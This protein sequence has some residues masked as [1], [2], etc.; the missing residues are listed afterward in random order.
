M[1]NSFED[2]RVN[3]LVPD[4]L[5]E[6]AQNLI[7]FL[8][9][10]YENDANPA[11]IIDF[12]QQNRD[13]DRIANENF[14]QTL[15]ETVAKGLPDSSVVQKTFLLKR[16]VDYYNLK[17][18]NESIIIFFQLFYDKMIQVFE[19]W[20]RVLEPSSNEI[21]DTKFIR[22]VAEEGLNPY[23]L[24]GKTITQKNSFGLIE[25]SG[26]VSR[27]TVE[28]YDVLLY[29]LYLDDTG[30]LFSENGKIYEGN[31]LYGTT[32]LSLNNITVNDG[33]DGFNVGDLLF[34]HDTGQ[35]YRVLGGNVVFNDITP[36]TTFLARIASVDTDGRVLQ[37]KLIQRGSGNSNGLTKFLRTGE[38]ALKLR[39]RKGSN[40]DEGRVSDP[41][42][43]KTSGNKGTERGLKITLN[44]QTLVSDVGIEKNNKGLLSDN[45]VL[46]SGTY[47][48]K[49]AYELTTGIPYENY[50]YAYD[51]LIHPAGYNLFNN[52]MIETTPP[53]DFREDISLSEVR[54]VGSA[55]FQPGG[56]Y[57]PYS[58]FGGNIEYF[59]NN[60]PSTSPDEFIYCSPDL[61]ISINNYTDFQSPA[62]GG[63]PARVNNFSP[64]LLN[65]VLNLQKNASAQYS[66]N[67]NES[68]FVESYVSS[69]PVVRT[70]NYT[71]SLTIAT[72]N[73]NRGRYLSPRFYNLVLRAMGVHRNSFSP[74]LYN[75][76]YNGKISG[77]YYYYKPGGPGESV[78][79]K[80]TDS[81]NERWFHI[82]R[83]SSGSP[84]EVINFTSS[85]SS[86]DIPSI[87][88]WVNPASLTGT[89][90][91]YTNLETDENV[92][93]RVI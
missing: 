80:P 53:V 18:T 34:L 76:P 55:N 38:T 2:I 90:Y 52:L 15:G 28:Q 11:L 37:V 33:G 44:F 21:Q 23:D 85:P 39:V 13:V 57:R 46:Q 10:Y 45:I 29:S 63:S 16:L 87:G 88:G 42:V 65:I 71:S 3:E 5:R 61:G 36:I 49:Y 62:F 41:T 79:F 92:S 86:K 58:I 69:S 67:K 82:A 84:A 43:L 4:Q 91:K 75:Y 78:I 6:T 60:T 20:S 54:T 72:G 31:T 59:T 81:P 68:Y 30:G 32:Y 47:Y 66:P 8:E 89:V 19:P 93:P 51:D 77:K 9:V 12:I 50:K 17:G 24:V 22:I 40:P 48:N 25:A 7:D 83:P 74:K 14:L 64:N 1:S 70:I 35:Q 56:T 27:V 26:T 73:Y